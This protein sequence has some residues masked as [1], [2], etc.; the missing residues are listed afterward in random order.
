MSPPKRPEDKEYWQTKRPGT[1]RP[2]FR[3]YSVSRRKETGHKPE[4]SGEGYWEAKA[5]S[6]ATQEGQMA[7]VARHST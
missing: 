4:E 5:K 3:Q 7:V 1:E 2:H 6:E